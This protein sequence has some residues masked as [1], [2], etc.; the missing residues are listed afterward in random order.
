ME[1]ASQCNRNWAAKDSDFDC[2]HDDGEFRNRIGLSEA[3]AS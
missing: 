2:L 3:L 1:D